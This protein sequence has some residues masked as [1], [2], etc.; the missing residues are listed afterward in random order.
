[1]QFELRQIR[2]IELRCQHL[3]WHTYLIDVVLCQVRRVPGD[4]TVHNWWFVLQGP[5]P[6]R[7]PPTEAITSSSDTS[8]ILPQIFCEAEDLRFSDFSGIAFDELT[9]TNLLVSFLT[10]H[11]EVKHFPAKEV[12][13]K[14]RHIGFL[15]YVVCQQA[16]VWKCPAENIVDNQDGRFRI[17]ASYVGV[18]VYDSIGSPGRS[19]L[20]LEALEA[21]GRISHAEV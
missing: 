16:N 12:R 5:E 15:G 4:D 13:D 1:M 14:G 10:A 11:F 3:E 18:G 8:K 17:V 19:S 7:S 9:Q 2:K 20:P 6:E 21:T